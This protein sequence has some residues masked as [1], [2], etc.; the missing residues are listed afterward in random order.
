MLR[1]EVLTSDVYKSALSVQKKL[2]EELMPLMSELADDASGIIEKLKA[3]TVDL[4]VFKKSA[5]SQFQKYKMYR[6]AMPDF[7][8]GLV[9]DA[10]SRDL[11]VCNKLQKAVKCV[12]KVAKGMHTLTGRGTVPTEVQTMNEEA[13]MMFTVPLPIRKGGFTCMR[14][15]CVAPTA[16]VPTFPTIGCCTA[17]T[18]ATQ[19]MESADYRMRLA[20]NPFC[21][22]DDKPLGP[23]FNACPAASK[24]IMEVLRRETGAATMSMESMV[25]FVKLPPTLDDPNA[26]V[27][28]RVVVL[29]PSTEKWEPP[30]TARSSVL[31]GAPSLSEGKDASRILLRQH[32]RSTVV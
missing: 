29:L 32:A 13:D 3:A 30:S 20:H 6:D 15:A 5:N 10:I 22:N 27:H 26:E 16:D 23:F 17:V 21:E 12:A 1:R 7:T 14:H 28:P 9:T 11:T 31:F 8:Q 18:T 2:V 19:Q 24:H 25:T 4:D